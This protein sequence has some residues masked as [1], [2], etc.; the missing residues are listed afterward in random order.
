VSQEVLSTL[1]EIKQ[2]AEA[3]EVMDKAGPIRAYDATG[4][5]CDVL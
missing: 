3:F 1:L 4:Y 2:G 5:I